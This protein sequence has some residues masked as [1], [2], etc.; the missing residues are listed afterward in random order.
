MVQ[1]TRECEVQE[2]S[3]DDSGKLGNPDRQ[4]AFRPPDHPIE[5]RVIASH[6]P[7]AAGRLAPISDRWGSSFG[8][9]L[10]PMRRAPPPAPSAPAPA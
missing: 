2:S 10:D 9:T 4:L 8:S 6:K 3:F 5:Y 7:L 1:P